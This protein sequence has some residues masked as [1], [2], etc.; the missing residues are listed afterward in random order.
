MTQRALVG[1]LAILAATTAAPAWASVESVAYT[2]L[3][4]CRVV[5]TREAGGPPLLPGTVRSFVFRNRCGIPPSTQDGGAESNVATALALNVVA[6]GAGGPGHLVA[7]PSNRSQPTASVINF[8]SQQE[9]G[10]LN[11]AN[12]II[13]QLCDEVAATPCAQGDLSFVAAVSSVHLVVDVVGYFARPARPGA[14]RYGAGTGFD[15]F[16]CLNSAEG[17]RFGLSDIITSWITADLACPPGTW[18]CSRQE[19]GSV[20]CNTARPDSPC[21]FLDCTGTCHNLAADEHSGW[22]TA[23]IATQ[24]SQ[25]IASELGGTHGNAPLCQHLPVWCCSAD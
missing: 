4:P 23:E 10:G 18:V 9:T 21:D 1:G 5:D 14:Q 13:L 20:A 24:T 22:L 25:W 8:S 17:V 19:R 12:G 15:N 11:V 6:V 2:P 7:W 16:L 3:T